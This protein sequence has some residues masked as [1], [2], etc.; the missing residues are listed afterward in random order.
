MAND[1]TTSQGA[2]QQLDELLAGITQAAYQHGCDLLPGGTVGAHVRHCLEFYQCLFD[3][4]E[5]GEVDYDARERNPEIES[6]REAA[7]REVRRL[8]TVEWPRLQVLSRDTPLRVCESL[9][10]RQATSLGRELGFAAS[11]TVHHLALIAVLL[12]DHGGCFVGR[13]FGFAPATSRHL[14]QQ[15]SG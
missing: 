9:E 2:L 15:S 10:A 14:S 6:H 1:L 7:L 5:S 4:L 11:H 12:R 13:E 3:G 8:R